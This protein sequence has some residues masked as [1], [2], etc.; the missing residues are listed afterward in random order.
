MYYFIYYIFINKTNT[1]CN[2]SRQR[3]LPFETRISTFIPN[4]DHKL[5]PL[6]CDDNVYR[7]NKKGLNE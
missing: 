7:K 2:Q 4:P 3:V 5:S 1:N 6:A